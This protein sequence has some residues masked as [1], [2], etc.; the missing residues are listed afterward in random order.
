VPISTYGCKLLSG[1]SLSN[2]STD[3]DYD[4]DISTGSCIATDGSNYKKLSLSSGLTKQIDANWAEGDNAGGFPSGL[5]LTA[6]TMY[7]VFLIGKSDGTVD[8]GFDTSSTAS[9]LLSDASSYSWYKHLGW[10]Y[11]E[12]VSVT[13]IRQF[14]HLPNGQFYYIDTLEDVE[15]TTGTLGTWTTAS[16]PA[17]PSTLIYGEAVCEVN[18]ANRISTTV[19]SNDSD[20]NVPDVSAYFN[21]TSVE[22]DLILN[23]QGWCYTDSSSQIEYTVNGTGSG[24]ETWEDFSFAVFGWLDTERVY[25]E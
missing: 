23:D 21:D 10:I 15:D 12:A 8:A 20:M 3:A 14:Y 13:K 1:L 5:S 16:V 24:S 9:N 11:Y 18:N 6:E 22:R 25:G 19:R 7:Q 17:P 4:I 2:N